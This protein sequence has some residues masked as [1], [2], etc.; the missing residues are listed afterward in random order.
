MSLCSHSSRVA[1]LEGRHKQSPRSKSS[2]LTVKNIPRSGPFYQG[3]SHRSR[4]L[5]NLN[6]HQGRL[7]VPILLQSVD[8]NQRKSSLQP[9][10]CR[11]LSVNYNSHRML[12]SESPCRRVSVFS[13]LSDMM[14]TSRSNSRASN[15]RRRKNVISWFNLCCIRSVLVITIVIF[16]FVIYNF[17]NYHLNTQKKMI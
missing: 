12:S 3:R 10:S 5:V 13:Q 7:Q 1:K 17:Y 16:V 9:Q 11:R 6:S 14:I 8:Q 4:S 15:R 2:S